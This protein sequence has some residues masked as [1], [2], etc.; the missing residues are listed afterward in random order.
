MRH[1][2]NLWNTLF[3]IFKALPHHNTTTYNIIKIG[4]ELCFKKTVNVG[5][6]YYGLQQFAIGGQ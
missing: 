2:L 1:Y 4:A 3:S 5:Y 6:K